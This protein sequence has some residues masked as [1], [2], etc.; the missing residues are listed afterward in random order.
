MVRR[1]VRREKVVVAA[2]LY[3]VRSAALAAGQQLL[4]LVLPIDPFRALE[5][6]E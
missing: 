5:A 4:R 6:P 1:V 2:H 3:Q